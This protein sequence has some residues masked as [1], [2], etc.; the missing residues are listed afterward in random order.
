[1]RKQ[2][3]AKLHRSGWPRYT[4]L[5]ERVEKNLLRS[6]EKHN[7]IESLKD[8]GH[9]HMSFFVCRNPVEKLLSIFDMKKEHFRLFK[10]L[11]RSWARGTFYTWP[12]IL[13]LWSKDWRYTLILVLE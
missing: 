2:P 12:Q 7:T 11:G 1:M 8:S 10:R 3:K 6:G 9:D 5:K 4:E 13:S